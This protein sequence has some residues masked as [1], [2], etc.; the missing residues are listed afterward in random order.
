M[1]LPSPH[2]FELTALIGDDWR[3]LVDFFTKVYLNNCD[4]NTANINNK[5]LLDILSNKDIN[6]AGRL[7]DS[8]CENINA[9]EN[10]SHESTAILKFT[11]QLVDQHIR[12]GKLHPLIGAQLKRLKPAT[13]NALINQQ[14]PW[15][16]THDVL[17]TTDL[18]Y[19]NTLGWQP[20]LGRA[21]DKFFKQLSNT[22]S[23]LEKDPNNQHKHLDSLASFFNNEKKRVG[24]VEKRLLDTEL[25]RL[26][27][28]H[29]RQLSARI[30]NQKM[31]G[32]KLPLAASHFLQGLWRE[33]MRLLIIDSGDD[34]QDLREFLQLTDLLIS[35]FQPIDNSSADGRNNLL[36][37]ISR[38][39]EKLS[40][41]IA[42]PYDNRQVEEQ[43][44]AIEREHLKALK[45][46]PLNYEKF[47]LIDNTNPL[48][49]SLVSV[50]S[51]LTR[52]AC[53]FNVGQWFIHTVNDSEQRIKLTANIQQSQQMLFTNMMG[54]KV[55][56]YG[57]EE[58]AYLLSS[59]V[60][61]PFDNNFSL[62]TTA[63]QVITFL[64][65]HYQKRQQLVAQ[66]SVK[67][68][69][70]AIQLQ[71]SRKKALKEANKLAKEQRED[72][73]KEAQEETVRRNRNTEEQR[74]RMIL[75]S[76]EKLTIG[77]TITS[78]NEQNES[79]PCKLAAIIQH[80]GLH[81]F[82]NRSGI[83][84]YSLSKE[85]I[86]ELL[87]NDKAKLIDI[88]SDFD[89]TLEKVVTNLRTRKNQ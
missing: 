25:G 52:H 28:R 69:T 42:T 39:S 54:I 33:S 5:R 88:G 15:V 20:E 36:E 61:I 19:A 57:Y 23:E 72:R 64:F 22:I 87:A 85:K 9:R 78:Y 79:S 40:E 70:A 58:I 65:G 68:K 63:E 49:N 86:A 80:S 51:S 24:K 32:K 4:D 16:D 12:S 17:T 71:K 11:D 38:L 26:D 76:L 77:G 62:S 53:S 89:N 41:H 67:E 48:T 30:L 8:V 35:S 3:L 73:I 56:Q 44:G 45:G 74:H 37:S 27:A 29:A 59:K 2:I 50:S 60:I 66:Q 6:H 84:E 75:D 81:I 10:L 43:L 7:V 82:V 14:I 31:A 46:Q 13:A 1:T 83:K 18:L 21:G 55:A 34:S 47:E